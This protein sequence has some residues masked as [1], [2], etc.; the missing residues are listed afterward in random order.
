MKRHTMTGQHDNQSPAQTTSRGEKKS[1]R[2]I[3][4]V[5]A[6]VLLQTPNQG[7]RTDVVADFG[8][9]LRVLA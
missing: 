3:S 7:T 6:R 9:V 5:S 1:E 8:E 2:Q 4:L